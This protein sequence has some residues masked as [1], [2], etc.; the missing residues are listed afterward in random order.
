[1]ATFKQKFNIK[2]KQ[3]KDKSNSIEDIAKLTGIKKNIL[4]EVYERGYGA[5]LSNPESVR[6]QG[7]FKKGKG[8]FKN[9][10]SSEMWAFGRLYGFVMNN[11]KQVGDKKPDEDLRIKI[12][13]K[14]IY[15]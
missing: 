4:Q 7:T 9:R 8:I 14:I 15:K 3:D 1:M 2:Y 6:Q 11:P 12:R 10:L 13:K 5:S